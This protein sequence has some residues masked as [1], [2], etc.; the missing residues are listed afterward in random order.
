MSR[1]GSDAMAPPFFIVGFQRSGTT[2]L[3]L[4][5]DNHPEVAIPLDTVGLW[6]RYEAKLAGTYNNLATEDD[7][8]RLV[9]DLLA[10]ERI[11]L[12]EVP[13]EAGPVALA[14]GPERTLAR[15]MDALH[16][17][18]AAAKGKARWGDKDPGNMTRMHRVNEWFPGSQFV[19]IVRDG[20]DACL[21][22]LKVEF[23]FDDLLPCACRWRE[24]V[25]WVRRIGALLGPA[26]YLELRYEDLVKRPE[27]E[28]RR[29]CSFL[30]LGY[31][32]EMLEYH[33]RVERSVPESRR[34][35]WPKIA[36]PPQADNVEQW[37]REMTPGQ[38]LCFEKRAGRLLDDLGYA[39]TPGP[40]TGGYLA[41]L[42]SLARGSLRAARRRVGRLL[43]RGAGGGKRAA[44]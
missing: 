3:R 19:H 23:G 11:R 9:G 12:W 35:I 24:E 33:R 42:G 36:R 14:V 8:R 32:P 25:E 39:T 7:L 13:L 38:V 28:L 18:Y 37:R 6:G 1:P 41:E 26:R 5:L 10:E 29:V 15:V 2:L 22:Q 44:L 20:R 27:E 40:W 21:S 34:H 30:G 4:M 16:R 43:K 31:A 17:A